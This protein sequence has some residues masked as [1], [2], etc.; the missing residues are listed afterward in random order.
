[1]ISENPLTR[2]VNPLARFLALIAGYMLLGVA[3]FVT[4][5]I[6]VRRFFNI[7]LQGGDE[8]G[9]Y[10][11]AILAAFGFSHALIE[12]AHTRVEILIERVGPRM[13]AMLNVFS[14]W[15]IALMAAFMAWRAWTTL[16][17]S[18]EYRSLSG[19]PLMTPLWQPQSLWFAGLLLFA[20]ISLAV[21]VHATLLML[22]DRRR[23]NRFY[24]IKTLEEVIEEETAT[25]ETGMEALGK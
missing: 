15:C 3:L 16:M 21:A 10:M 25:P 18:V 23:L 12:R 9:G 5:E 19:T 1:M 17:E 22:R 7:S 2:A 8:L 13:Q 11:L 6:L 20:G 24:G 4:A 14:A